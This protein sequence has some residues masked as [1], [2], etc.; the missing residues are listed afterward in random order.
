MSQHE[1]ILLL[2]SNSGER[3]IHLKNAEGLIE[4]EIGRIKKK[5]PIIE[6]EPVGFESEF[7]FLNQTL[8][9]ETGLSPFGLLKTVKLIES[10]LG[11]IYLKTGQ[12][13]QD[14]VIDID[15]LTYNQLKFE[16]GKLKI[17]HHQIITRE[18]V[19]KIFPV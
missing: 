8:L 2:G 10:K 11:R 15:I 3:L 14:R 13:Y 5:S 9:V 17:P 18:F 7:L 12:K 19:Q 4:K 16:C 1:A 6:T